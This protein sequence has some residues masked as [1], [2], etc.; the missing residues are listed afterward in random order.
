MV[1]AYCIQ[2]SRDHNNSQIYEEYVNINLSISTDFVGKLSDR[3]MYKAAVLTPATMT[4]TQ[5]AD[6]LAVQ[7]H[8]ICCAELRTNASGQCRRQMSN[9][10]SAQMFGV[11]VDHGGDFESLDRNVHLRMNAAFAYT[12]A[13]HTDEHPRYRIM[14]VLER[15]ET[16][17]ERYKK[18]VS[19]MSEKFGGDT[20]ARDAVRIWYGAPDAKI[21]KFGQVLRADEVAHVIEAY[22]A[23]RPEIV[24]HETFASRSFTHS[25]L[26]Q[27][28]AKT[29]MHMEHIEYKRFIAGI[30]NHFGPDEKVFEMLRA[31][32]PSSVPYERW[33][34]HR[35]ANVRI[36]TSIYI[37]KNEG[38]YEGPQNYLRDDPKNAMESFDHVE[39]YLL[40]VARF[41]RNI[42]KA[43]I[44]YTQDPEGEAETWQRIDDYFVN[45]Q[46]RAMTKLKIKTTKDR[47]WDVL[48]SDFCTSHDAIE[49]YFTSLDP[50]EPDEADYIEALVDM[51]PP[52]KDTGET[53][54]QQRQANIMILS[55]WLVAAYRCAVLRQPNHIML[56]FQGAQG[57]G[58][59]RLLRHLCP[60]QL[61]QSYFYEGEFNGERD[62]LKRIYTSF[63][64]VDDE[65]GG[66]NKS[67]LES[68]KSLITKD[69]DEL[70]LPY[71]RSETQFSRIV[72]F[73]GTVNDRNF[74]S[75]HTGNRRFAPIPV[76]G[77]IKFDDPED[78]LLDLEAFPVD[79]LWAQVQD[80]ALQSVEISGR[81][82]YVHRSYFDDGDM[83]M[84]SRR[85]DDFMID[86]FTDE[87]VRQYI[88][89][90]E[91]GVP[92]NATQLLTELMNRLPIEQQQRIDSRLQFQ[93]G[94][95]LKRAGM[96]WV[97][98]QV[99]GKDCR[100]YL[101]KVLTSE[102]M[103][104]S[105][106]T[107]EEGLF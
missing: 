87:L 95:S 38:N 15:P 30:F 85:Q 12:T 73:A 16:N 41:R 23:A 105:A 19:I 5:I 10:V 104:R 83:K 56:V 91:S 99:A 96:Q 60:P 54:A 8:A 45:S 98:R 90:V 17:P 101:A 46:V 65:L 106:Q 40:S 72:S 24:R 36:G 25:D 63:M 7:G 66:M 70:R 62:T 50:I 4:V 82:R 80:M 61:R 77:L 107:D 88:V 71:D 53:A 68:L 58:K 102:E 29:P 74:L 32:S 84:L 13:S 94:R 67:S 28:L 6:H 39:S 21:I 51:L 81:I 69:R 49:E 47:V 64:A 52:V 75:D 2:Q 92:K 26:H 33:Y 97:R 1:G 22:E 57:T 78:G 79:R 11:D 37:A 59:T 93:F 44:E 42:I 31:W 35:M 48:K 18:L 89:Q 86:N 34:N 3:E 20:N 55:R 76:G 9:F 100:G 14:F 103:A 27:M 43:D